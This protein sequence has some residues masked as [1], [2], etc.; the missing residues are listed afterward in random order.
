MSDHEPT[1]GDY[2]IVNHI[3]RVVRDFLTGRI[4]GL[5]LCAVRTDGYPC[6]LYI[7][8][9]KYSPELI[10][11]IMAMQTEIESNANMSAQSTAPLH[12]RSYELH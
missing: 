11:S 5:A 4:T 10:H 6:R 9:N 12:N 3:E 2:M 1:E 8:K 7:D